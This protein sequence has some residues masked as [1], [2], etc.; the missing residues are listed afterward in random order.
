MNAAMRNSG[1][2]LALSRTGAGFNCFERWFERAWTIVVRR[3]EKPS[4]QS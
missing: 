3:G 2:S 4:V 1:Y